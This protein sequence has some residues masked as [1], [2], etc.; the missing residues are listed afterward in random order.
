MTRA[1]TVPIL[2]VLPAAVLLKLVP[3]MVTVW[4]A[5]PAVGVKLLM[6]GVAVAPGAVGVIA[7]G[8]VATGVLVVC[9]LFLQDDAISMLAPRTNNT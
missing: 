3:V 9:E 5:T 1:V 2:T 4:L 8:A 7:P 6:E